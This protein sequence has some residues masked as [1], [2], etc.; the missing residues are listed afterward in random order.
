MYQDGVPKHKG[1]C[2]LSS[3]M[4]MKVKSPD[5][6]II[7]HQISILSSHF[8]VFW[9]SNSGNFFLHEH[10]IVTWPLFCRRTGSKSLR[11]LYKTH[12]CHSQEELMLC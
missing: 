9:R 1:D 4:N 8:G 5:F 7:S 3:S 12:I 11:P 10:H 2:S 6:N